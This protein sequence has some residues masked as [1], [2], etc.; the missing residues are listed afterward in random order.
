MQCQS[1]GQRWYALEIFLHQGSLSP[2]Q[3]QSQKE[4]SSWQLCKTVSIKQ[5]EAMRS[6]SL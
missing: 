5:E 4:P 3:R 1:S 2:H 6:K